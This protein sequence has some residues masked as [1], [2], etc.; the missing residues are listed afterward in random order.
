MRLW[1]VTAATGSRWLWPAVRSPAPA[2]R[3]TNADVLSPI[4]VSER[5]K[6]F[7]SINVDATEARAMGEKP[8]ARQAE[9]V[10][11][12]HFRAWPSCDDRAHR[13]TQGRLRRRPPPTICFNANR[14]HTATGS[15]HTAVGAGSP[16]HRPPQK[17]KTPAGSPD[18]AAQS[19]ISGHCRRLSAVA[20]GKGGRRQNRPRR[21]SGAGGCARS[22]GLPRFG[23]LD[24]RNI[25]GPSGAE[26]DR[27]FRKKPRAQRRTIGKMNP[28]R[29]VWAF[30][31]V[32][33]FPG[34]GG[35]RDDLAWADG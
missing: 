10:V 22:I 15:T 23:L 12:A 20:S 7:F 8:C 25:Y 16:S 17:Q 24:A 29:A 14:V 6:V 2:W 31:D 9:G 26:A 33:R 5:P 21:S 13:R 32:D 34:R 18:G 1:S 3:L 35:H 30:G 4:T 19:E 28:D 11:K 27:Q